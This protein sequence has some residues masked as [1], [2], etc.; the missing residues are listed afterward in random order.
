MH[1][2]PIPE[3]KPDES[4]ANDSTP[5]NEDKRQ[6][7]T[8]LLK[9]ES[10]KWSDREIAQRCNVSRHFV[11]KVRVRILQANTRDIEPVDYA[12]IKALA[13]VSMRPA[14]TLIALT[15]PNDPFY[16]LPARQA[17]AEWFA[18]HWL[19]HCQNRSQMHVRGIH[20][21]LISLKNP[22]N[23]PRTTIPYENTDRCYAAL[24]EAARRPAAW[25]GAVRAHC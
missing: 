4:G 7:V 10:G 23:D 18:A 16:I 22:P 5:V 8:R 17:A 13:A 19:E 3:A 24:I 21:L 15:Y 1:D 12:S 20:Y 11:A 9:D 2:I 25:V 14:I 6:A